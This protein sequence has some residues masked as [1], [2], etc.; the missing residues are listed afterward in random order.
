M[1]NHMLK[2]FLACLTLALV[3]A[4]CEPDTPNQ[5]SGTYQFHPRRPGHGSDTITQKDT[6]LPPHIEKWILYAT[7]ENPGC[8]ADMRLLHPMPDDWYGADARAITLNWEDS[9]YTSQGFFLFYNK[10][11]RSGRFH[12]KD[13]LW[14]GYVFPQIVF[15]N[16][17][18]MCDFS[19]I[20]TW[21]YYTGHS[22]NEIFA[23]TLQT[24]LVDYPQVPN[25]FIQI[26]AEYWPTPTPH[27]QEFYYYFFRLNPHIFFDVNYKSITLKP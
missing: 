19:E 6:I 14:H 11:E 21:D 9:T 5:G 22:A 7:R 8:G 18:S 10:P 26:A 17:I 25:Q 13:T 12:L 15:E 1:K 24:Y 20:K 23:V 27:E 16:G 3:G 2:L 4:A